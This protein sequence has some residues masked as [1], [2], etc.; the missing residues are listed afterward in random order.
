MSL[1]LSTGQYTYVEN[2]K[3]PASRTHRV[4][5]DGSYYCVASSLCVLPQQKRSG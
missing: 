1:T 5:Q 2:P 3:G 4:L